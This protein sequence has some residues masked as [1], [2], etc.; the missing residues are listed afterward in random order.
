MS[1]KSW[2]FCFCFVF[3]SVP[4]KIKTKQPIDVFLKCEVFKDK[5]TVY[6]FP[7]AKVK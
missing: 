4:L 6:N 1:L 3:K 5:G 7:S 2:V